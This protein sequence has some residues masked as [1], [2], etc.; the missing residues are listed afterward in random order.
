ML[1]RSRRRST[2]AH[3]LG[4]LVIGDEY[5]TDMGVHSAR[6]E[7]ERAVDAFAAEFLL[8]AEAVREAGG[9]K[10]AEEMRGALVRLAA[11]FRTSWS[12]VL[13]QAEQAGVIEQRQRLASR[14]PTKAELMDA[15]GWA[16]EPDLEGLHVPPS[17]AKAVMK[18]WRQD[19]ITPSRAMELTRGQIPAVDLVNAA[20][21]CEAP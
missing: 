21:D 12:M 9:Q 18:A 8:P 2:A 19:L 10:T 4:H 13:R 16:P 5:S 7:R 3:E 14:A 6:D 11:L 20:D 15:A 1:F 17:V